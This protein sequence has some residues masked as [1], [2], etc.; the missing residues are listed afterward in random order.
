MGISL[1][2]HRRYH[3]LSPSMSGSRSLSN[4]CEEYATDFDVI[5]N[6]NKRY[7][8]FFM[9]RECV[10]YNIIISVCGQVVNCI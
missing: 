6:D 4:V 10:S 7:L 9:S 2:I 5:F 3:S 1:V 8:L